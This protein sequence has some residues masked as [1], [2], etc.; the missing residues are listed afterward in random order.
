MSQT[1]AS[2]YKRNRKDFAKQSL[3]SASA[4]G[5]ADIA[6]TAHNAHEGQH[7][8]QQEAAEDEMFSDSLFNPNMV[9]VIIVCTSR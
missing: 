9:S 8:G 2:G 1:L 4:T 5:S 7:E 3:Q 6:H